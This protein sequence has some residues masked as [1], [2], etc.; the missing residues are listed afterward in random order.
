MLE[1]ISFLS[2]MGALIL[3]FLLSKIDMEVQLLPNELVLGVAAAGLIFHLSTL[4]Y[5]YTVIDMLTGAL[6]GGGI[7]YVIRACAN[8]YYGED[9]L[10]LGDVK[11]IAAGGIWL[12][13][14]FVLIGMTIGAFLGFLHGGFVAIKTAMTA[15]VK[16]DINR[17]SIPA[18]PGFC[19]GLVFAAIYKFHDLPELLIP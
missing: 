17:L 13:P 11:L 12:G 5:Y 19:L 6:I 3:L 8:Y 14:E 15:K 1:I 9:T 7:L 16:V 4:F 18:G 10:G 2:I